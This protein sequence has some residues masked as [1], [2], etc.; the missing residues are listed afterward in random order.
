MRFQ[1]KLLLVGLTILV[2]TLL[3]S[4]L[5]SLASFEKI[6]TSSL[7]A[8][9]EV[10]G[11]V[12]QRRIHSALRLGK[13]L[14]QFAAME[15]LLG[16]LQTSDRDIGRI[17]VLAADKT[18]LYTTS[19]ESRGIQSP[20]AAEYPVFD[21]GDESQVFTHL[22]HGRYV[23][24]L[25]LRDRRKVI[26]GFLNLEFPRE[27]V[28]RRLREMAWENLQSL[29]P[30]MLG[31]VIL[32]VGLNRITLSRPIQR[33]VDAMVA[34]TAPQAVAEPPTAEG[35]AD[36]FES[37]RQALA[38]VTATAR[39]VLAD[40]QGAA[41]AREE[42]REELAALGNALREWESHPGGSWQTLH[43]LREAH[44]ALEDT[45]AEVLQRQGEA[46]DAGGRYG[47]G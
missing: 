36:E 8:T 1:N 24:F 12:L 33:K 18:I 4:S 2:L 30:I 9:Y 35:A 11:K 43:E 39:G 23:T 20:Y 15:Q 21:E 3:L 44:W 14:E 32:L 34:V 47:L 40:A 10:S 42:L 38:E 17:D 29:T 6:F 16:D 5:L 46:G 31:A 25:P 27:V 37:L 41:A 26:V 13:P 7:V 19:G 22:I 45:L 28:F